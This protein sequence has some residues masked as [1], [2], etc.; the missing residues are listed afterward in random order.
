MKKK[1]FIALFIL[2]L[3]VPPASFLLV[4]DWI[5]TENYENRTLAS[6]PRLAW[7]NFEQIPREFEEFLNDH[8]PYKNFFVKLNT[9]LE[10]KLFGAVSVGSVTVGT[11]N[12][13]FYTVDAEGEDALSEIGRAHV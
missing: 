8:A 1:L 7:D 12:W 4:K 6:F 3:I 10:K 13:L 9:K 5:D 2:S 11:D